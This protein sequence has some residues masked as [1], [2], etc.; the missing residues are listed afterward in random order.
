MDDFI[1]VIK[2]D[3]RKGIEINILLDRYNRLP[4]NYQ[5]K[6]G[7]D[8]LIQNVLLREL[9]N[10]MSAIITDIDIELKMKTSGIEFL[11]SKN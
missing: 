9:I 1:N 6:T 8:S 5:S 10:I 11:E 2:E 7:Y 4:Y 3:P